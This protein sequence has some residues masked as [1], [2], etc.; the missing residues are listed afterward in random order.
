LRGV[1]LNVLNFLEMGTGRHS[2][3]V[4]LLIEDTGE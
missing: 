3:I 2:S 1:W 4:Q